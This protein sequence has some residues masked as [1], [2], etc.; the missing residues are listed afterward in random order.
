MDMK[1]IPQLNV[2]QLKARLESA[3]NKPL[4]LDVRE[5]WEIRLCS[6]EGSLHIPMGQVPARLNELDPQREIVVL[7]HH[8]IRSNRV[9]FFLSHQ[10]Y[11][12]VQNLAGGVN[13]WAR[14]IDNTMSTY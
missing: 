11:S 13:A 10:G 8:G 3:D 6:L 14:E 1:V 12:N 2:H 4:L 9:A 5:A 7:C